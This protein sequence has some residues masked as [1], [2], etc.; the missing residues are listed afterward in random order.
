VMR[1]SYLNPKVWVSLDP[2]D[3]ATPAA[4]AGVQ[5]TSPAGPYDGL[6]AIP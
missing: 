4:I 1:Q 3:A 6:E 5:S 2:T